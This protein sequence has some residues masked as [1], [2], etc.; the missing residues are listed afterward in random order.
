MT[1]ADERRSTA[2]R[3]LRDAAKRAKRTGNVAFPPDFVRRADDD[4]ESVTPL[5]RLVQGGRGG[6]VR[7]KVYLCITMMAT[8]APHN[9]RNPPT[10]MTWARLLA[11]PVDSG[12]RRVNSNL[13]W[14][15]KNGF[16]TLQPRTA[17]PSAITLLSAS[18]DGGAYTRPISR[19]VGMPIELWTQ[20]WLIDLSPT[21]LALLLVLKE[22]QGGHQIPRYVTRHR[23]DAYCL[24]PDTWTR[25][26]K[27][28]EH[29]E[30]LEVS[31]T[32]QGSDFDY[33]RLRNTY[34]IHD[35]RLHSPP[36]PTLQL[37]TRTLVRPA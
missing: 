26:T 14:L 23:R 18:G 30:L 35:E 32:P 37:S 24:S 33:R 21:A 11:L 28:L 29:H 25:A 17:A 13:T 15:E 16:I 5:A 19:Y 6:A 8:R 2:V 22:L 31:R 20:G 34:R 7:L 36:G 10:P 9:I 12:R 3:L 4:T 27:E 1:D